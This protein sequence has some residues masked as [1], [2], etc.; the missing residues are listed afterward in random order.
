MAAMLPAIIVATAFCRELAAAVAAQS[1]LRHSAARV[2]DE[3]EWY[4][5]DQ[6]LRRRIQRF[7]ASD[8]LTNIS[9]KQ[10]MNGRRVAPGLPLAAAARSGFGGAVW[11][12][13][14]WLR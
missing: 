7:A 3:Q 14:T 11:V 1:A 5:T 10:R 13:V 8:Q 12:P 9:R 4:G 6:R 2:T